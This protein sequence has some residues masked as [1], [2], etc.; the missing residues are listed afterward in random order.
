MLSSLLEVA[1]G[2]TVGLLKCVLWLLR[3]EVGRAGSGML[4][5][6][7]SKGGWIFADSRVGTL[8]S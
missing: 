7:C 4:C 3:V 8:A 6:R 1:T 5:E 2:S